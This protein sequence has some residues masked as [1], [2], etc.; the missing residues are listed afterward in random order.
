MKAMALSVL[1][2][3]SLVSAAPPSRPGA[4]L[5]P[6]AQLAADDFSVVK[7][8]RDSRLFRALELSN[9]IRLVLVSDAKA[10]MAGASLDVHVGSYS[11]PE[12]L[13]GL[14]HFCEHMLF[15]ASKKYTKEDEY[16]EFLQ[17]HGGFANAFTASTH[18][19]Y[20]FGVQ[21]AS[22]EEA[23]D[24]LAQFFVSPI[25]DESQVA[26]EVLAVN[27][28]NDK[29]LQSDGNRKDQVLRSL[30]S[31]SFPYHK[32]GCGNNASLN[33]PNITGRLSE[34]YYEHYGSHVMALTVVSNHTLD[35]LQ[36]W[37]EKSFQPVPDRG[38]TVPR[39]NHR[40]RPFPE[41]DLPRAYLVKPVMH[42]EELSVS[43][44]L[45]GLEEERAG[46]PVIFLSNLLGH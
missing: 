20:F 41:S 30:S 17:S 2:S 5:Q 4:L 36:A 6:V 43:F 46:L 13:P 7:A 40:P 16:F 19:N 39:F 11:D 8:A 27:A 14:A 15:L 33:V 38:A 21:P 22:L 24:R 45:P 32:Y 3:L 23:M 34:W 10:E 12:D 25:F 42:A 37:A 44:E 31:K 1:V 28:E 18:T 29:N 35:E 26:R 9:G